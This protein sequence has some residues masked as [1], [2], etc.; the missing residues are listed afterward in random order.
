MSF[1]CC[2]SFYETS[3]KRPLLDHFYNFVDELASILQGDDKDTEENFKKNTLANKLE[4][5]SNDKL[6]E[7]IHNKV[8]KHT[9]EEKF[10]RQFSTYC[11]NHYDSKNNL[12]DSWTLK[13]RTIFPDDSLH[14]LV[15]FCRQNS[16][17]ENAIK[18]FKNSVTPKNTSFEIK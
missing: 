1:F 2:F 5:P 4:I 12:Q 17:L 13:M 8:V 15:E 9:V 18:D 7:N 11:I 14:T 6:W 3:E 10:F 16:N